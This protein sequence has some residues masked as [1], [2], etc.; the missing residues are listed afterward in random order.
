MKNNNDEDFYPV[1]NE[2]QEPCILYKAQA[3]ASP[4]HR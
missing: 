4:I 2:N 3:G 1:V